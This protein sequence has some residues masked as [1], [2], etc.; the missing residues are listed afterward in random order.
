MEHYKAEYNKNT[1]GGHDTT[2]G[3][4]NYLNWLYGRPSLK[5]KKMR[6]PP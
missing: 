6:M 5:R 1:E 4:W 2:R 3:T